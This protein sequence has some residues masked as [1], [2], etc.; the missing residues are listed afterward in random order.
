MS[1]QRIELY[2]ILVTVAMVLIVV[3]ALVG[4]YADYTDGFKQDFTGL[5]VSAGDISFYSDG[6]AVLGDVEFKVHNAW[7]LN[8]HYTVK[9]LPAGEDFVY[10]IEGDNRWY[11]YLN[12]IEDLTPFFGIQVKGS[13]FVMRCS[14]VS[15]QDILERYY[16]KEVDIP[17]DEAGLE[18]F[19]LVVTTDTGWIR[20]RSIEIEFRFVVD[21]TDFEVDP[22]SVVF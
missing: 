20:G 11:S 10:R 2:V 22:P 19:K 6:S 17:T 9:V 8:S 4:V 21:V 5:Y 14:Q 15:I 12:N 1:Q 3:A 7:D 18:H 16:G 13:K